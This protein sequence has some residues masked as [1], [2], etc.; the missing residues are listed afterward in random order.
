MD[1]DAAG[2]IL[3]GALTL[4]GGLIICGLFALKMRWHGIVGAGVLAMLGAVRG[5]GN[6]PGMID[7]LVGERSRG[8]APAL[9]LGI[10]ALCLTLFLNVLVAL[11]RERLRRALDPESDRQP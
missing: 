7:F 2:G 10:T 5:I 9:E 3:H 1:Q 4:G 11:F 8:A 6:L